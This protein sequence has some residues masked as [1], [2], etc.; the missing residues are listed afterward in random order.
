MLLTHLS[1]LAVS[2]SFRRMRIRL[3][4]SLAIALPTQ[5]IAIERDDQAPTTRRRLTFEDLIAH[6]KHYSAGTRKG[7]WS[8]SPHNKSKLRPRL[9]DALLGLRELLEAHPTLIDSSLTTL[10]NACVRIIGDEVR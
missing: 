9:Q 6:V 4:L 8:Y 2:C 3:K 7:G 5:S 10:L 1:R